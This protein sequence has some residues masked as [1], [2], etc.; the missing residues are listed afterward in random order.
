MGGTAPL[1]CCRNVGWGRAPFLNDSPFQALPMPH[2]WQGMPTTATG[3]KQRDPLGGGM[4]WL[5]PQGFRRHIGLKLEVG[6]RQTAGQHLTNGPVSFTCGPKQAMLYHQCVVPNP[7]QVLLHCTK[8][9]Y[10]PQG[11]GGGELGGKHTTPK[12]NTPVGGGLL[13][14]TQRESAFCGRRVRGRDSMIRSCT[15]ASRILSL[16]TV[17]VTR[18]NRVLCRSAASPP[19][20]E[21]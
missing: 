3:T 21:S 17:D 13:G 12:G 2:T 6:F 4:Q 14:G 1:S 5:N 16:A 7:T 15:A 11:K 20:S 19:S 8:T 18:A 10:A 9:H